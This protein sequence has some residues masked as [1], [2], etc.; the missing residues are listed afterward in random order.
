MKGGKVLSVP[1]WVI[2][3]FFLFLVILWF[4]PVRLGSDFLGGEFRSGDWVVL[5]R[6]SGG[7]K[8]LSVG[9]IIAFRYFKDSESL[10]MGRVITLA[11]NRVEVRDGWLI[12]NG[13]P[14][15]S[16]TVNGSFRLKPREVPEGKLF[17]FE[18]ANGNRF[19]GGYRMGESALVSGKAAFLVFPPSR[20]RFFGFGTFE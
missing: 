15:D 8:G 18:G 11:G 2:I 14:L 13:V 7:G 16:L 20:F 9:D 10:H 19:T 4:R 3:F 17:I 1:I 5:D 6:R 12:V